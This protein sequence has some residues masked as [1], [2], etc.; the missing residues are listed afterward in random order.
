MLVDAYAAAARWWRYNR[1][2]ERERSQISAKTFYILYYLQFGCNNHRP[3]IKSA[4]YVKIIL[5]KY[6]S[7]EDY[8]HCPAFSVTIVNFRLKPAH[9]WSCEPVLGPCLLQGPKLLLRQAPSICTCIKTL[10]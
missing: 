4:N 1:V 5:N 3:Q 6:K 9:Y 8:K 2:C 7:L 10:H